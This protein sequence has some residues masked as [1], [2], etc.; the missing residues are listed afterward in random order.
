ME[1]VLYGVGAVEAFGVLRVGCGADAGLY[2]DA[3][4]AANQDRLLQ[5]EAYTGGEIF[6]IAGGDD[7]E[8]IAA[9]AGESVFGVH[10]LLQALS[11]L[12]KEL[13][14]GIVAE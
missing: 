8:L 14:A 10:D 9:E 3:E 4:A 12:A 7:E 13:I 5:G 6:D 2:G 11:D 1:E